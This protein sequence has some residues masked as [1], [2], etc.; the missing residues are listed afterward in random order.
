MNTFS[1]PL[2]SGLEESQFITVN[3]LAQYKYI[4]LHNE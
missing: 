2:V 1:V 3:K 4:A